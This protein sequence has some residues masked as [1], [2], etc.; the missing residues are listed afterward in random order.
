MQ[1]E[2]TSNTFRAAQRE[3]LEYINRHYGWG[4]IRRVRYFMD[5][6]IE[7]EIGNRYRGTKTYLARMID[8]FVITFRGHRKSINSGRY[9]Q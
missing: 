5:G 7:V 3:A 9:P 2:L 6:R 4:D 8:E 1:N